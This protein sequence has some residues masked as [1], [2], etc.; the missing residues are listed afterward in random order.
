MLTTE[1]VPVFSLELEI[2]QR[3]RR[4]AIV[5]CN[6]VSPYGG[7]VGISS[8]VVSFSVTLYYQTITAWCLFY[9]V[10]V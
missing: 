2:G 1:G 3:L 8:A 7:A 6:Q 5:V 9:C 10:Q 4:G